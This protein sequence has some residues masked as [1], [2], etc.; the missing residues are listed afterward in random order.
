MLLYYIAHLAIFL[1]L[2]FI[3]FPI[4]CANCVV[5]RVSD[6]NL[7]QN[8]LI[9]QLYK[10]RNASEKRDFER[11]LSTLQ[12]IN[13]IPSEARSVLENALKNLNLRFIR[14]VLTT[15]WV[16][17]LFYTS[18]LTTKLSYE[19]NAIPDEFFGFFCSPQSEAPIFLPNNWLFQIQVSQSPQYQIISNVTLPS[20]E[21]ISLQDKDSITFYY[22]GF[23]T[24]KT[25]IDKD[26]QLDLEK[27]NHMLFKTPENMDRIINMSTL[28]CY[29]GPNF[30]PDLDIIFAQNKYLTCTSGEDYEKGRAYIDEIITQFRDNRIFVIGCSIVAFLSFYISMA[31][32]FILFYID[33]KLTGPKCIGEIRN[34]FIF[35]LSWNYL[36]QKSRCRIY[37]ALLKKML[38]G[39]Q[40]LVIIG[41]ISLLVFGYYQENLNFNALKEFFSH[42]FNFP[43]MLKHN[44]TE[45][46]DFPLLTTVFPSSEVLS[47]KKQLRIVA[48]VHFIFATFFALFSILCV[49]KDF[50]TIRIFFDQFKSDIELITN[51]TLKLLHLKD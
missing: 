25:F 42:C 33:C 21:I 13:H 43:S 10:S 48:I 2:F 46:P 30:K 45:D 4:C 20:N 16:F 36:S 6:D 50:L 11:Y 7:L 1:I 44:H 39:L 27:R 5:Y 26:R 41:S 19:L 49:D 3:G 24:A 17:L 9:T 38:I 28:D 8:D 12:S 22:S 18:S 35:Y 23:C 32:F 15:I 40:I 14:I 37:L 34:L 47:V 29:S 31:V 51:K